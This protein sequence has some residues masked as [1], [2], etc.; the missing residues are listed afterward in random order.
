MLSSA[1]P[2]KTFQQVIEEH[3]LQKE[4]SYKENYAK[5]TGFNFLFFFFMTID[6]IVN[7]E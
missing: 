4:D 2:N 7:R 5:R 6:G 3:L 1:F